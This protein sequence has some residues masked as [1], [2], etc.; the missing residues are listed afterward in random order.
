MSEQRDLSDEQYKEY[1]TGSPAGVQYRVQDPVTNLSYD[2]DGFANGHLVWTVA[3]YARQFDGVGPLEGGI[4]GAYID[5]ARLQS[6]VR[7]G[8]PVMWCVQKAGDADR[9]RTLL[10]DAGYG[11]IAVRHEAP[12]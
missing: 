12:E 11:S 6:A 3:D 8:Y 5:T 7:Q 9:L 10:Q 1:I 2:F 4:E